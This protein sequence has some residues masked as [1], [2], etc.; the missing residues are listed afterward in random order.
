LV[1]TEFRDIIYDIL[2]YNLDVGDCVWHIFTHFI[3]EGR[4]K[5]ADV[6]EILAKTHGFFKYYNNNYRPIYHLENILF[7]IVNKI[8]GYSCNPSLDTL[9]PTP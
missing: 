1:M 2:V 5:S 7:F 6:S 9:L 3:A 4:L 8:H